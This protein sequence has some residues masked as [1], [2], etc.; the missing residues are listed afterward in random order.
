[1]YNLLGRQTFV[2][3]AMVSLPQPKYTLGDVV[4]DLYELRSEIAHG[5][6]IREGFRKEVG[7]ED[8]DGNLIDG[9]ERSYQRRQILEE[10]A[11]FL[12]CLALRTVL[13]NNLTDVVADEGRWR[14]H[15]E[16]WSVSAASAQDCPKMR[17]AA[18]GSRIPYD[19]DCAT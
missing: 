9:Y 1:M 11:L 4:C 3:P 19:R 5:R 14:E 15:L 17:S 13:T 10:T 12:L 18:Q 16:R 2:F 6:K 7:F 8:V